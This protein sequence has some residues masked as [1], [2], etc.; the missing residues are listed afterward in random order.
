MRRKLATSLAESAV[1]VLMI[2]VG[3]AAG[4][5]LECVDAIA[6]VLSPLFTRRR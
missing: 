2:V 6:V 1:F 5:L 3:V 4:V